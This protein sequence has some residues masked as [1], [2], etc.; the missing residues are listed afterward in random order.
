[1]KKV[2]IL[3]IAIYMISSLSITAQVLISDGFT[4]P[5]HPSAILDVQA[6]DKGMLIPRMTLAQ[7]IAI[8]SPA[9]GLTVYQI[10]GTKGFYY[11]NG[12][13]WLRMGVHSGL[14]IGKQHLG[15]VIFYLDKTGQSGLI[16]G[17][18]DIST[19]QPW[20]NIIDVEIGITAQS[21][22][23]SPGNCDA[24]VAQNGHISS[25]AQLCLDWINPEAGSGIFDDWRL[26]STGELRHLA[27]NIS[28]VQRSFETDGNPLTVTIS[29][30]PYW[31]ATEEG[32]DDAWGCGFTCPADLCI[33]TA[34][35]EPLLVRAVRAF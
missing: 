11:F 28:E 32:A 30:E 17:N 33:S 4:P 10:N 18:V 22:W 16:V 2:K 25:A 35:S 13:V 31:T 34:K 21:V 7:R 24:T 20:S 3:L 5:P 14:Y 23:N 1:M 9:Q 29:I 8:A 15:G 19:S 6:D 26:G 12:A 27:N